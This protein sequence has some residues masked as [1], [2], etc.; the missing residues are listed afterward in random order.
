[1]SV[2]PLRQCTQLPF[3]CAERKSEQ[4]LQQEKLREVGKIICLLFTCKHSTVISLKPI[5]TAKRRCK[6]IQQNTHLPTKG[7]CTLSSFWFLTEMLST[8]SWK[9]NNPFYILINLKTWE[10]EVLFPV[11]SHFTWAETSLNFPFFWPMLVLSLWNRNSAL[12]KWV[13][14][15]SSLLEKLWKVWNRL[16]LPVNILEV[17]EKSSCC[18]QVTALIFMTYLYLSRKGARTLSLECESRSC[19]VRETSLDAQSFL[20]VFC[21]LILH[22]S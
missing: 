22:W 2:L 5:V 16:P 13:F 1:M 20:P 8:P 4:A 15:S 10:T 12:W 3:Q 18:C 9:S 17:S 11:L 6:K 7:A 21:Q 14:H 19:F